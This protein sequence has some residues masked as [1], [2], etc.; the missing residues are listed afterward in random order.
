VWLSVSVFEDAKERI[1]QSLLIARAQGRDTTGRRED[2]AG[3]AFAQL[4]AGASKHQVLY[5]PI[6]GMRPSL[7]QAPGLQ[8]IDEPGNVRRIA[9]EARRQLAHGHGTI[10]LEFTQRYGLGRC[11]LELGRR[12]PQVPMHPIQRDANQEAPDLVRELRFRSMAN[13]NTALHNRILVNVLVESL[14]AQP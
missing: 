13:G 4:A 14:G 8:S 10:Q 11:Q 2:P 9:F 3:Q 5:P 12:R 6:G 1:A 7:H